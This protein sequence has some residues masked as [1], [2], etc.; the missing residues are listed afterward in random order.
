[1]LTWLSVG[2]SKIPGKLDGKILHHPQFPALLSAPSS[3]AGRAAAQLLGRPRLKDRELQR[4]QVALRFPE[5][6]LPGGQGAKDLPW[7]F[8]EMNKDQLYYTCIYI[9]ND[10]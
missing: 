2:S 6:M 5:L 7:G 9:I 4:C 1:M 10:Y 3:A 8:H